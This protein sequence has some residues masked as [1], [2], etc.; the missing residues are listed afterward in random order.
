[1][2]SI[3][4]YLPAGH[5]NSLAPG[6]H[7]NP[8][9]LLKSQPHCNLPLV[10]STMKHMVSEIQP[11]TQP[12][13]QEGK[14]TMSTPIGENFDKMAFEFTPKGSS[15]KYFE[16]VKES[17]GNINIIPV[18]TKRPNSSISEEALS[19]NKMGEGASAEGKL[20]VLPLV[21]SKS[22]TYIKSLS[23]KMAYSGD[24]Q[25]SNGD[26]NKP[27][28]LSLLSLQNIP[29]N[30][31]SKR[32]SNWQLKNH[33]LRASETDSIHVSTNVIRIEESKDMM[34][35]GL[36]NELSE[37]ASP[38]PLDM[39]HKKPEQKRVSKCPMPRSLE[40]SNRDLALPENL[41]LEEEAEDP[42]SEDEDEQQEGH[43]EMEHSIPD[44]FDE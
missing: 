41:E 30:K 21:K 38:V 7:E 4:A 6:G 33:L 2:T 24:L 28:S 3:E 35:I 1:M 42:M 29:P 39:Q 17:D 32:L 25:R 11:S 40:G 9:L 15:R 8:S 14:F 12:T 18:P 5:D 22:A 20:A 16:E 23:S 26:D 37:D 10:N 34:G 31:R 27:A 36:D 43:E 19:P 44:S 13:Q